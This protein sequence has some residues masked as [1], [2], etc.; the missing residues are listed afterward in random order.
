MITTSLLSLF[1]TAACVWLSPLCCLLL[2][3]RVRVCGGGGGGGGPNNN[4]HNHHH[5]HHN[6]NNNNNNNQ[7]MHAA[8]HRWRNALDFRSGNGEL[9]AMI[10]RVVLE[11]LAKE[12]EELLD[13]LKKEQAQLLQSNP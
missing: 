1:V 4:N 11:R 2:W 7:E 3:P 13:G 10:V 6:N 5:H 8:M 12:Q 9:N